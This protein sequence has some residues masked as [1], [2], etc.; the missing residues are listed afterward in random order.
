MKP[1]IQRYLVMKLKGSSLNANTSH[2]KK[3]RVP[4]PSET[5]LRRL[6]YG[7]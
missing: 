6:E 1:T 2:I 3:N 4:D 7:L 5:S